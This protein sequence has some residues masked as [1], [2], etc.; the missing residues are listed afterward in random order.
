MKSDRFVRT[1]LVIIALL[2]AINCATNL[3]APGSDAQAQASGKYSY[4]GFLGE[5]SL[6]GGRY[7]IAVLDSRNGNVWGFPTTSSSDM[8]PNALNKDPIYLG[9]F[10]FDAL[11]RPIE[12]R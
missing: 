1:M 6:A 11:D 4:V 5:K 2:L 12:P 7:C 3:R 9:K 8:L 10:H